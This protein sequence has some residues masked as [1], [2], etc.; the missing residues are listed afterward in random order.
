M[1][2]KKRVRASRSLLKTIPTAVALILIVVIGLH[3]YRTKLAAEV[4][5][6]QTP[7]DLYEYY[8]I[9]G[10]TEVAIVT[11]GAIS[12][13]KGAVIDGNLYFEYETARR[14]FCSRL[15]MDKIDGLLLYAAPSQM[16]SARLDASEYYAGDEVVS[17]KLPICVQQ[18]GSYYI[19]AEYLQLFY[20]F[21]YELFE[22]AGEPARATLTSQVHPPAQTLVEISDEETYVRIRPSLQ[23]EVLSTVH[24][25]DYVS[26]LMDADEVR[27]SVQAQSSAQSE[28]EETPKKSYKSAAPDPGWYKVQTDTAVIGYVRGD[29]VGTKSAAPAPD[30]GTDRV[31]F[32]YAAADYASGLVADDAPRICMAWHAVYS[33]DGNATLDDVTKNAPGLQIIAPTWYSVNDEVGGIRS[34]ASTDY[35]RRAHAK[36]LLVWGTYDNFNYAANEGASLDMHKLLGSYKRRS[37]LIANI[38]QLAADAGLDGI[39]I[40]FENIT[41]A[42]GEDFVEFI[43]ELSQATRAA[44]ILLSVD[45]PVPYDYNAHYDIGEQGVMC[46]YVIVMGYDEFYAGSDESGSVASIGYVR[47]GIERA[48]AKVPA[49]KVVNALPFYTRIWKTQGTELTSEAIPMKNI[50]DVVASYGMEPIWD[51]ETSQDYADAVTEDGTVVELWIEDAASITTKINVMSNNNIGGVAGWRLGYEIPDIWP[52]MQ[53][54]AAQ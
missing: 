2:S 45:L 28:S 43:R 22:V 31:R 44:G 3:Y 11:G 8:H 29:S 10:K 15:Y 18:G 25:G 5:V 21:T 41:T 42:V 7:A 50:P 38:M 47:D 36:G 12:S 14:V 40:D 32:S 46:D 34:F 23:A 27:S 4:L 1:P 52:L 26:V 35:V 49:H 39:N 54:F 6:K 17:T 9:T 37:A 16:I 13:A 33:P 53:A 48:V 19:S 20:P 30:F 24:E 51:E